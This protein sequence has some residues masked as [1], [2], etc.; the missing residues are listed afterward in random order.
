LLA[1][2]LFR[3]G[4]KTAANGSIWAAQPFGSAELCFA[5]IERFEKQVNAAFEIAPANEDDRPFAAFAAEYNSGVE[6][7]SARPDLWISRRWSEQLDLA[8]AIVRSRLE[9]GDE[10][11]AVV[12]PQNSP[13]GPAV[14]RTLQNNGIPPADEYRTPASAS[15]EQAI[16]LWLAKQIEQDRQPEDLLALIER[17]VRDPQVYGSIR[18]FVFRR[19]D[20]VQTRDLGRL[21]DRDTARPWVVDLLTLGSQ[22]PERATWEQFSELWMREL[23][24]CQEILRSAQRDVFPVTLSLEP[25]AAKR[26]IGFA[27]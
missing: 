11:L 13:T 5:A 1:P 27:G 18:R 4:L 21:I 15:R 16:Q 9:A 14:V 12:V 25:F 20:N 26:E 6:S 22:W 3:A 2:E 7:P 17:L 8:A 19:F 24:R 10:R 23:Q